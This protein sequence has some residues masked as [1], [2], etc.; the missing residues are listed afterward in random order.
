M[1]INR[2]TGEE[3]NVNAKVVSE[4]YEIYEK[5]YKEN[6][7]S[8]FKTLSMPLA[9]SP[10]CWLGEDKGIETFLKKSL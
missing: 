3:L 5:W 6:K 9:G 10:Y 7:K 2:T 8:D 4:V 1:L